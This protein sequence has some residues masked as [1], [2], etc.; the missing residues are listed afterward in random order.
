MV[1]ISLVV[2][3]SIGYRRPLRVS[4]FGPF[5]AANLVLHSPDSLA[6]IVQFILD[7]DYDIISA[8]VGRICAAGTHDL[9]VDIR[10]IYDHAWREKIFGIGLLGTNCREKVTAEHLTKRS[11]VNLINS[12][13]HE[14]ARLDVAIGIYVDV[15]RPPAIHPPT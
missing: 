11:V 5:S 13:M 2:Y 14:Y 12:K 4:V 6:V 9:S 3:S 7:L 15:F 8:V 1:C 10:I